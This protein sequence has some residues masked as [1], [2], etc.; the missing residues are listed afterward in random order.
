MSR[1]PTYHPKRDG[2]I[3]AWI[4]RAAD[5]VRQQRRQHLAREYPVLI[6]ERRKYLPRREEG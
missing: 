2:P 6:A 5:Q 3:F 4:L 1:F